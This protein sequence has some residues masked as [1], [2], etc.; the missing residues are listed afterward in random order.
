MSSMSKSDKTKTLLKFLAPWK[1]M[2]LYKIFKKAD[3]KKPMQEYEIDE[4]HLMTVGK[5]IE[6]N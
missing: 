4:F 5:L 3:A 1:K 2:Y 6:E